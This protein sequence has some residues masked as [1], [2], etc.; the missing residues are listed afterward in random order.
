MTER[1]V[2]TSV[3]IRRINRKD[4]EHQLARN[5]M[6]ALRQKGED[7][8]IVPQNLYELWSVCTRPATSN[9][10]G[11]TP[12]QSLQV[13]LHVEELFTLLSDHEDLYSEWK[14]IVSEYRVSGRP[15]HDARLIAAMNLHG[16][17]A[18]L[19]FNVQDFTRYSGLSV[20]HPREI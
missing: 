17:H 19:T 16:I 3:L 4:P 10:L 14:R 13:L 1:L 6:L 8:C 7:L 5:A 20:L 11:L 15:S 18:L 2:D 9:G 12:E